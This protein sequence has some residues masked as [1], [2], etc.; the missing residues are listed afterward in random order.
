LLSSSGWSRL[1]RVV[2][3]GRS[4]PV[5]ESGAEVITR[6]VTSFQIRSG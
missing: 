4:R 3:K 5:G 2:Y 6:D 1:P